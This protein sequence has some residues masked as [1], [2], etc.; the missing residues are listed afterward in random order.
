LK[1]GSI[2][3]EQQHPFRSGLGQQQAVERIFMKQRQ[4]FDFSF[5]DLVYKHDYDLSREMGEGI[6]M[7]R[8]VRAGHG[9]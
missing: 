3:R 8:Y 1:N 2:N 9:Y 4:R 5:V 6:F 7:F